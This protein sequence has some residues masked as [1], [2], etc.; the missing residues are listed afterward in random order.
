MAG[1]KK[2]PSA[3]Y[4]Y[5]GLVLAGL[6]G[7]STLLA[8]AAKG[9][10]A[11]KM[12][13]EDSVPWLDLALQIS[14][15]L[16]AIGLL[17]YVIMAPDAV[18]RFFTGRQARY[19][20]NSLILT[21][22]FVG[23]IVV[24]NY[25][26]FQNPKSWDMTEDK[27]NTLADET[28]QALATL[29]EK[30]TATAFYS[31]NL[32][33]ASADELLSKF[34]NNS[35]G[36]FDYKF[37]DPDLDPVAA[38]EAGITG[39]G[40][41]MLQMGDRK[42]IASFASETE[43]T[44]AMI[45]L[46]SPTARVVYFLEGHGEPTLDASFSTAKSTLESKNYTVNSLNLLS[47]NKIPED[48]LAIIIAGP[49]KPVSATEVDLLKKYVDSGGSLV[50]MEDPTLVTEFG[51]SPDPLAEYL[52]KDWG[53]TLDN[54][55]VIDLINSQNPLQAVSS[56]IGIHPITQ[57]LTQNY[58]V[59]LPQAR[60]LSIAGQV[61]NVNQTPII[62]TTEQSWGETELKADTQ[63]E[64]DPE[65]DTAGPLNLAIAGEN[66]VTK[67]RVVVFGNSVFATNDG[68]DAY[69]NGNM[70]INSV[71]WAAEQ[72]DL[73]NLTPRQPTMRTFIPP[74]NL[75]FLVMIITTVLVLPGF[76]VFAGVSAW[77]ARRKRG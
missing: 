61:E 70:F 24:A 32:N 55:I 40:K 64:F 33:S 75:V 54:D 69:G 41:I 37:V 13:P 58:I 36:K 48:A 38:R 73:I 7:V 22:A 11:I 65:K 4:A 23:I 71:D 9:M 3:Q 62:L 45:R 53:I 43:L 10:I 12:F 42:E 49:M 2:N 8:G 74:N 72:E 76:V 39:D 52:T 34:K 19:G 6:A 27:S 21:L 1:N 31:V 56:N 50:V 35:G 14:V 25:L 57:N 18:R 63:P 16:S 77:V 5:I 20:S 29:P 59:I 67:G 66:G 30:V 28:L 51:D 15:A 68:F 44:K 60:S 26:V 17:A 46:I 47:T